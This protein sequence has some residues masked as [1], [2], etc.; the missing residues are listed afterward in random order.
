MKNIFKLTA[1]LIPDNK[2]KYAMGVGIPDD[3]K[4]ALE[5][6]WNMFDTVLPTRMARH[7][8]LYTL[9]G[10]IKLTNKKFEFDTNPIDKNCNCLTCKN[11]SRAYIRHLLKINEQTGLRLAS[12]HNLYFFNQLFL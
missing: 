5:Y 8:A 10:E 11:Y 1:D 12:I 9:D 4:L 7:G 2:P 6:G 3:I